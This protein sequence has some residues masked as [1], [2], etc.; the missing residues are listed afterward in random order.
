[1]L[2]FQTFDFWFKM[3]NAVL[4]C[5]AT[6]AL[7]DNEVGN[8][9]GVWSSIAFLTSL[10]SVLCMVLCVCIVDAIPVSVKIKQIVIGII[11]CYL[12]LS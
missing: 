4:W 3:Y 1:M 7:L 6:F 5:I 2:I 11:T 10:F 8:D 12:W 9:N